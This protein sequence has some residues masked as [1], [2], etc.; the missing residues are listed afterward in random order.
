[1]KL[2]IGF[3]LLWAALI[4]DAHGSPGNLERLSI[5]GTDHVRLEDWARANNFAARWVVP[6][7]E[8]KLSSSSATLEFT[9]D[10]AKISINGI[11]VWLSEPIAL[12]N[13]GAWISALD[14]A[15]AIQ[16][17]LSTPR[18]SGGKMIKTIV[19][20]AGHG[21]KDPGKQEGR[22]QEKKYTLLLAKEVADLLN[23]AGLKATLTR[24]TDRFLELP[25]RPDVARRR[26]ADLFISLHFN[27]FQGVGGPEVK[28]VEVYCMTPAGACST[29]SRGEGGG[30]GRY[31]GNRFDANNMLLGYQMQRA[32][33][34]NLPV[35]DR[36]VRRAR[37][38]VLRSAEMPAVLIEAGFMSNPADA[39]R[40]YDATARRQMAAA[41]VAGVKAYKR[42]VEPPAPA[43]RAESSR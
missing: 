9:V 4:V 24:T 42:L 29:N 33:L 39:K 5:S 38:A 14:L 40:I 37:W 36:G 18:S 22:Q 41:I 35:E 11:H 2:A 15:T 8:L 6:K 34:K 21:G 32:L 30:A 31:P 43:D 12:R 26:G 13:E 20:D 28:G 27:A 23:K 25:D 7:Q 17:V 10:S 3:G 19:L 16:P 1:M